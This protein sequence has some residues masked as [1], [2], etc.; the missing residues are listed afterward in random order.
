MIVK[1]TECHHEIQTTKVVSCDWC[2]GLTEPI[3]H[4]YMDEAAVENEDGQ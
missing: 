4:D 3:G 2:G 1:C